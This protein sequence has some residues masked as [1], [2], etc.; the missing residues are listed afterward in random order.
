VQPPTPTLGN[1]IG[2][3]RSFLLNADWLVIFPG[4]VISALVVGF[5]LTGDW[6]VRRIDVHVQ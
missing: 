3:G 5:N 2:D 6:L 4:L 1:L